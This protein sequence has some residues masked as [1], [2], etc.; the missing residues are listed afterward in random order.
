MT[1]LAATVNRILRVSCDNRGCPNVYDY[2]G[3]KSAS[4]A[5]VEA[6][7]FGWKR[8]GTFFVCPAHADVEV[9]ER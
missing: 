3:P 1:K 5:I 7:A 6:E 8:R 9:I 2:T 4:F